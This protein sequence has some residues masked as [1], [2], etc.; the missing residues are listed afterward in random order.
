MSRR[1]AVCNC[2]PARVEEVIRSDAAILVQN[3]QDQRGADMLAPQSAEVARSAHRGDGCSPAKIH[4][5]KEQSKA[6]TEPWRHLQEKQAIPNTE[7]RDALEAE[8]EHGPSSWIAGIGE[9]V[10]LQAS[11][12]RDTCCA[13]AR[14]AQRAWC[15]NN[16]MMIC[17]MLNL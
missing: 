7:W 13:H 17:P 5:V 14:S 2:V 4:S 3:R 10:Y 11:S 15:T 16:P 6:S 12:M 1:G 9:P 8:A